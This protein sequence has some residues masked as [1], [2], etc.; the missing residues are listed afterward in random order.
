MDVLVHLAA[1][2]GEVVPKRQLIASTWDQEYVADAVLTRAVAELRRALGDSAQDPT[3]I[4]TIPRR[5]YRLIAAVSP[6][7]SA[8]AREDSGWPMLAAATM[9]GLAIGLLIARP[10]G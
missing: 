9:L 1:H 3:Y 10:R 4:E 2:A 6:P 8:T 7:D 5:G